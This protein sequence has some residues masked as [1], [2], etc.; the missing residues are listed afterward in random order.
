MAMGGLKYLVVQL[1]GLAGSVLARDGRPVWD[2]NA[3]ALAGRVARPDLLALDGDDLEPVGLVDT[4]T[5]VPGLVAVP[6]YDTMIRNLRRWFGATLTIVDYRPGVPAPADID[7]LRVPY[8]FR[9]S[10]ADAARTLERAV[11][12]TPASERGVI[13]LAHSLGGLVARYWIA[14]LGGSARCRALSTLGTPHRGAPRALDVLVNGLGV[15]RLRHPAA[16]RVLRAWPSMHELLPQYPAVRHGTAEIE[17]VGLPASCVR[18]FGDPAAGEQPLQHAADAGKVHEAIDEAWRAGGSLAQED[19]V[20]P[21]MMP[22]F[23]RGH[24]TLN[25]ADLVDDRLRVT[26]ADPPWRGNIGWRGDGTVPVISAIPGEL[27]TLKGR[28]HAATEKHGAMAGT[29]GVRE[30]LRSLLGDDVPTRGGDAPE[31]PWIGFDLDDVVWA[32]EEVLLEAEVFGG[33]G[34]GTGATLT[35][36]DPAGAAPITR[37]MAQ[38]DQG[39]WRCALP[40]LSPGEYQLTVQAGQGDSPVWGQMPLVVAEPEDGWEPN[41]E[42]TT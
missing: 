9:R 2:L 25:R 32:G 35:V 16:T 22:F 15:G 42:E 7:V 14:E 4:M 18:P 30:L 36:T 17:P 31:R 10:V 41:P 21:E 28:G 19:A 40:E 12:D 29:A 5:V 23:A 38:S 33:D 20:A 6:G 26:K 13:V 3:V 39:R 11:R 27:S 37:P 1:P 24:G 34:P 8:D